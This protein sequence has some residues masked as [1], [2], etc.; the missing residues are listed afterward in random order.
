VCLSVRCLRGRRASTL[1]QESAPPRAVT[2]Y[3]LGTHVATPSA[4]LQGREEA[5]LLGVASGRYVGGAP[6][7]SMELS[8]DMFGPSAMQVEGV[9]LC[10]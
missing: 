5:S 3:H 6:L 4:R 10:T 1:T 8:W 2:L 9:G 7:G